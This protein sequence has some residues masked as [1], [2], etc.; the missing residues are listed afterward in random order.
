MKFKYL[1]IVLFFG[2]FPNISFSQTKK[3][4]SL[5]FQ[6]VFGNAPLQLNEK[7]YKLSSGDSLL[8]ETLKFYISGI[9][10]LHKGKS[11]CKEAKS[12]HLAD[13]SIEKSLTVF[14]KTKPGIIFDAVKFNLGID[15]ATNVSGALG[16]DLD[17]T[18]GMYWAWQSGYIN[19]KLEGK[20]NLCK[21]RNNEFHFHLGGYLSPFY[22]LKTTTLQ[23]Q[24]KEKINIKIDIAAFISNTALAKENQIM[25]PSKEAVLLSEK[26]INTFTVKP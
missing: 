6:P 4:I 14:L 19:F 15:S 22:A 11:V 3:Q 7:Y 17:P 21:T 5:S 13:A 26:A 1:F 16:G 10:L 18:K 20:S 9:E 23:A 12:F 24:G 25:S 2:F 8:I